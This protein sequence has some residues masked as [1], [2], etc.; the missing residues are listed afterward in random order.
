MACDCT[1]RAVPVHQ[2]V[3]FSVGRLAIRRSLRLPIEDSNT[4]RPL[5]L[6]RV[7]AQFSSVLMNHAAGLEANGEI[8]VFQFDWTGLGLAIRPIH[9]TDQLL[10]LAFDREGETLY[11]IV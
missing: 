8:V 4:G 7:A 10:P 3:P 5:A 11:F 1:P 2:P 9:S 6:D